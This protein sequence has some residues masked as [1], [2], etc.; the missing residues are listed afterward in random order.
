MRGPRAF[1]QFSNLFVGNVDA[2]M[3]AHQLGPQGG[4]AR[5]HQ[6]DQWMLAFE[7]VTGSTLLLKFARILSQQSDR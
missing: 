2:G 6:L 7:L 5:T 1:A 4:L 3:N